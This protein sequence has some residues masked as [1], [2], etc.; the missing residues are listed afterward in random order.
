MIYFISDLHYFHSN[1]FKYEPVRKEIFKDHKNYISETIKMWNTKVSKY[2]DVYIVGDLFVGF[3]QIKKDLNLK[4]SQD[5][6][7]KKILEKLNG[8]KHLI[9][10]NHDRKTKTWYQ[11]VGIET[12][13][14]YVILNYKGK[15]LFLFHYPVCDEYCNKKGNEWLKEIQNGVIQEKIDIVIHGHT[16]SNKWCQNCKIKHF[17]VSVEQIDFKPISI[18]D[19]IKIKGV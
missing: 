7:A 17:N 6:F 4:V 8:N 10:G 13:N 18:E 15:K 19:I 2:D 5:E 12:V 9:L 3:N 1:I 11:K 14:N 16:H